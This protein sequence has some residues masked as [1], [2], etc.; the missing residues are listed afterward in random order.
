[1]K[2]KAEE[3]LQREVKK[4]D[5]SDKFIKQ[6]YAKQIVQSNKNKERTLANKYKVQSLVY[7]L[8]GVF[9]KK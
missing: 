8:D 7:S 9:C 4:G 1:M 2:K 5:K 6:T 3:Q